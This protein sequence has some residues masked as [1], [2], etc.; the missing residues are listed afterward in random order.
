MDDLG[1]PLFQ[2]TS[3]IYIYIHVDFRESPG[4]LLEY[5]CKRVSFHGF[6]ANI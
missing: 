2:E 1:V 4:E 6:P 3:I 5:A